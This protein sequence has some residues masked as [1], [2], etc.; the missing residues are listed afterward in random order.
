MPHRP[1]GSL[2]RMTVL[3]GLTVSGALP[4]TCIPPGVKDDL[5]HS[6]VV[7]RGVVVSVKILPKRSEIA[8]AR[9]AVTFSVSKYWK[10]SSGR[11]VTLHVVGPGTD[12]VGAS[13]ELGKEYIVFAVFQEA[14]DYWLGNDFWYGWLDVLPR[15]SRILTANN[16][17]DSTSEIKEGM[18]TL[19][20]LGRGK[21][22]Q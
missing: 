4:C 17:C 20:V 5:A 1:L 21:R 12:C 2:A 6:N 14:N 8:R 16:S 22:P 19:K 10:G 11:S 3:F 18:S 13:F 9:Y 7:F 15:G